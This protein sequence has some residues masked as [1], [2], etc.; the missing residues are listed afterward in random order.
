LFTVIFACSTVLTLTQ[1][2]HRWRSTSVARR[3]MSENRGGNV[4]LHHPSPDARTRCVVESAWDAVSGLLPVR[5]SRPLAETAVPISRQ[6]GVVGETP[7]D[8]RPPPA[9]QLL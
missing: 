4:A 8:V 2:S 9:A 3:G 5:F 6:H 7:T 1:P